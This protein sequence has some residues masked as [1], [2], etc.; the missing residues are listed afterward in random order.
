MYI[1]K[2]VKQYS[3]YNLI[4]RFLKKV[5]GRVQCPPPL[6]PIGLALQ[7]LQVLNYVVS[8]YLVDP[9]V[10][11]LPNLTSWFASTKNKGKTKKSK[12]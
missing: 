5:S 10:H 2:N 11:Q 12:N 8:P 1:K 6:P 7:E 4:C 3:L 9:T